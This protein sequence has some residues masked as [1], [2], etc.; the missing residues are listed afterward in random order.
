MDETTQQTLRA[1]IV[2]ALPPI[3]VWHA[4]TIPQHLSYWLADAAGIE[5][6]VGG[7]YI[8]RGAFGLDL[9]AMIERLVEGRRLVLR[10]VRRGDDAEIEIDLV[11][12]AGAQTRVSVADWD[13]EH[14][15][16]W[17]D[18]LQN[19]RSV[20]ERGVDLRE[21]RIGV[22]GIGPREIDPAER[23]IK[24]VPEGAGV[25]LN[26][27]LAGGAAEKAGLRAGDVM[28]SFAGTP[29]LGEADFVRLIQGTPPGAA[30][31][32]EAVRDG[33]ALAVK[34]TMGQRAG[35]GQPPAAPFEIC[36]RLRKDNE[37]ANAKLAKA[38]DGLTDEALYRPE[39]PKK[40]SVA[41][42]LA[43]LSL[44]E[45]M[46]QCWIDEAARGMR[47]AIDEAVCTGPARLAAALVGRPGVRAL[48]ERLERDQAETLELLSRTP[49]EVVSFKPCWARV[50][51][52]ALDFH[53]HGDDH[54]GQIAR[55][56]KAVGA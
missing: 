53:S 29:I 9:D 45:R 47:P 51:Y 2:V 21:T 52:T 27:V 48:L 40:W 14:A 32:V 49:H 16:G 15:Q 46:L 38:L 54:L 8:V 4:F 17:H 33:K 41:Q 5:L 30:V 26:T 25:R 24:G 23:P 13:K 19:L 31:S 44:T 56:R 42:V 39:T 50:A 12:L 55:I 28:I 11:R 37:A 18:A 3:E 7:T 22:M 10:P 36:E 43:H 20:W 34:V 35:R 6:R 1:E